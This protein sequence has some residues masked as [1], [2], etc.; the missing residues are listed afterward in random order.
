MKKL[1]NVTASSLLALFLLGIS[2]VASACPEAGHAAQKTAKK[3]SPAPSKK[4]Q[5]PKSEKPA[6]KPCAPV[7]NDAVSCEAPKR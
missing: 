7:T 1:M 6:M 3:A 2:T 4:K 5:Q